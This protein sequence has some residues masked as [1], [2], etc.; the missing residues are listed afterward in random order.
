MLFSAAKST[1]VTDSGEVEAG[2]WS[3]AN[4]ALDGQA[5][6][7]H[8]SRHVGAIATTYFLRI[9]V[10]RARALSARQAQYKMRPILTS[11]FMVAWL[12]RRGFV[13]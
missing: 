6:P 2:A 10:W 7:C 8:G 1:P 4:F 12:R 11:G 13:L 3:M 9:Q 5:S